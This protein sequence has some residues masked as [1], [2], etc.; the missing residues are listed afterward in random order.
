MV[1][2]TYHGRTVGVLHCD[3]INQTL[4]SSECGTGYEH[5]HFWWR[6]S[7]WCHGVM[8]VNIRFWVVGVELRHL[9]VSSGDGG[10]LVLVILL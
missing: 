9:A 5:L 10:E 1:L 4:Q 6:T 7:I 8:G 3:N 2:L